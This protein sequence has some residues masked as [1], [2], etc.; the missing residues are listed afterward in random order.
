MSLP[1]ALPLIL[2]L[3][4]KDGEWPVECFTSEAH[5]I[6]WLSQD[7]NSMLRRRHAW[8]V[9]LASATEV[10]YVPPGEAQLKDRE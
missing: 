10:E 8:R 7:G 6:A 2:W 5:V 3:G 1:A 4:K 9:M